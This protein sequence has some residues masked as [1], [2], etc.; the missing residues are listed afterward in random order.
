[1]YYIIDGNNLAGKIGL[2]EEKDFDKKLIEIIKNFFDKQ[3]VVLVFDSAD[4]LGDK[5]TDGSLTIVYTPRDN[6]YHSADD[7]ILEIINDKKDECILI[8]DD[9]DITNKAKIFSSDN[10]VKVVVKKASEFAEKIKLK[11][12]SAVQDDDELGDDSIE[13]INRELLNIWK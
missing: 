1:M 10:R 6:Y 13:K 3:K 7:K 11:L 5:Y 2:L 12:E 9:I 8:T 4:P